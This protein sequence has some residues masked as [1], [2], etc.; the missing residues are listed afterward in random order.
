M[1][2]VT[3][4]LAYPYFGDPVRGRPANNGFVYIGE[5]DQDPVQFPKSLT[6][7]QEDGTEVPLANP[8][9]LG[10]GGYPV[11]GSGNNIEV[12]VDGNYSMLVEDRNNAQ[13]FFVAN[14]FN[15]IPLVVGDAVV[16]YDTVDA[17]LADDAN[18][19]LGL[20]LYCAGRSTIN[21]R[22]HGHYNVV[23]F[24]T[25]TDDGGTFLDT[26]NNLFQLQLI[27][28]GIIRPEQFGIFM[29]TAADFS[30]QFQN[31]VDAPI[32]NEIEIAAG[33]LDLNSI[34]ITTPIRIRGCGKD[35]TILK[36]FGTPVIA[37]RGMFMIENFLNANFFIEDLTADLNGEG[38]EEIGTAGFIP[39][40]YNTLVGQT[41]ISGPANSL[42]FA[43]RASH[44]TLNRVRVLNTGESGTLF[45]NCANIIHNECDFENTSNAGIEFNFPLNDGGSGPLPPAYTQ[46]HVW[47]VDCRLIEDLRNGAG[48]A[49]G[50][51]WGGDDSSEE[52]TDCMV[53]G[54]FD[55]CLR[56]VH[57]EFNPSGFI[58]D[59]IFDYTST[60]AR[61]G[62]CGLVGAKDGFVKAVIDDAG[63]APT[64]GLAAFSSG[65]AGY[66]DVYGVVC[67]GDLE[68]VTLQTSIT[69][70][71][72]SAIF[73]GT[74]A[75]TTASSTTITSATAAFEA[76][77]VGTLIAVFAA[78][79][80]NST[81]IGRIV[82]INSPT[83]VEV[84][85]APTLSVAGAN[86]AYGGATRNP[87]I[88]N[89]GRNISV[90][91]SVIEAGTFSSLTAGP[92]EPDAAAIYFAGGTGNCTVK[93]TNMTA[94]ATRGTTPNGLLIGP[95]GAFDGTVKEQNN[96]IRDFTD[97]YSG[98]GANTN[99]SLFNNQTF[100]VQQADPD[101]AAAT[102]G[103]PLI[104]TP[105]RGV[106][107]FVSPLSV[108]STINSGDTIT[109][110]FQITT[111][112]NNVNTLTSN[113]AVSAQIELTAQ[114]LANL[115]T[116]NTLF[117]QLQ[118]RVQSDQA[119]SAS[120]ARISGIMHE[121]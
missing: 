9:R 63:Y 107:T 73:T 69:D 65:G 115:F 99:A 10:R 26:D 5:P 98:F 112:D 42:I 21:D 101:A 95:P 110:E 91:D 4:D 88:M 71:R 93:G 77:D 20:K 31:M 55:N 35:V 6:A 70:R 104:L 54:R 29:D 109:F 36:K 22:G 58:K 114:Q 74:D 50:V 80:S 28:D 64:A 37:D 44:I 84:D 32:T 33:T 61:Q 7:R 3:V 82:T 86:Y 17:A 49:V 120:F 118:F 92:G 15:G 14:R 121:H 119:S 111:I 16:P 94:P 39:N 47:D 66:P 40:E 53:T 72:A 46:Y 23:A 90:E 56:D 113:S 85:K 30:T 105:R 51:F 67:S 59:F 57:I 52:V 97:L 100:L 78:N 25:G 34:D 89:S 24:G 62:S 1:A 8:F 19:S 2:N 87:I 79:P 45:R 43:L 13:I 106:F 102:Y 12:L 75:V 60:E 116:D 27:T 38:S 41:G 68:N 48:N 11:D 83:S 76:N 81:Y 18:L 108:E 96:D 117:K 103:P